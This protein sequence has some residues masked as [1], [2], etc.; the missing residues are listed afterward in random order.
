MKMAAIPVIN[1]INGRWFPE[2]ADIVEFCDGAIQV[3]YYEAGGPCAIAYQGK[4]RK[5][6]AHYSF[7]NAER[8]AQAVG[9]WVERYER[10]QAEKEARRIA[11]K[12]AARAAADSIQI[13]DVFSAS[14]G[15][16]QTNVDYYQVV[17]KHGHM[18]DVREIG[19]LSVE[20]SECGMSDM[21]VPARD[22][23][24]SDEIITKRIQGN[25][26][27]GAPYIVFDG[28][29]DASLDDGKPQYRSWY[30]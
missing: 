13:G 4:A 6:F 20:G 28:F 27:G 14:W 5:P 22:H 15:Y 11:K 1:I 25:A 21:V 30:Y 8:R 29:N 2:G 18:V 17:G 7:R 23:F 26:Y 24:V 10:R 19:L 16:E 12:E 3:G 9:E